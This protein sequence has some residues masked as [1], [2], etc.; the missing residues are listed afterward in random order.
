MCVM[1]DLEIIVPQ[2]LRELDGGGFLERTNPHPLDDILTFEEEGHKY[3]VRGRLHKELHYL[4]STTFL[5]S[6]FPKF[7]KEKVIGYIMRSARYANDPEYKY[8]RMSETDILQM[9]EDLGTD[10]SRRGSRFHAHVEYN[11][12]QMTVED[13]S[14][15]F[16]QYQ[17]FRAEN[18]N[19]MPW[20]TEMLILHEE[21]RI[22]GSVDAIFKDLATGK[23]IIIDWKR[24]K[25]VDGRGG[26]K[27]YFPLEKLK[28]NNL[29]KYSIQLSLYRYILETVYGLEMDASA[30][31]ICHPSQENY[32]MMRTRYMKAEVELMLQY[33]MLY[34]YKNG[35]VPAPDSIM[36]SEEIDWDLIRN[37]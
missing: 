4:S 25:K 1:N 29:T 36:N 15:E 34:L 23:F 6:F 16:R 32:V 24:S 12:N 19:L 14:P 11:C 3:F 8:Y 27:G 21:Y 13:N 17:R 5:G 35:I 7:D 22:V 30:L 18:P 33:R 37:E 20:R 9:W 26:D 2:T 28:G 31:V 10:A